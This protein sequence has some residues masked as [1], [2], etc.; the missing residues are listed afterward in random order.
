MKVKKRWKRVAGHICVVCSIALLIIQILDWYNPYMDFM[1]HSMF[2][3]YLLCAGS[4]GLGASEI[5]GRKS[6]STKRRQKIYKERTDQTQ[7]LLCS[8]RN[9]CYNENQQERRKEGKR[10]L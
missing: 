6:M 3:L 4:L 10:C 7:Q 1:G 5:Y 8:Q 9:L 2:L